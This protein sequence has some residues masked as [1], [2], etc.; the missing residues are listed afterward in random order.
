[1]PHEYFPR[2]SIAVR[3]ILLVKLYERSRDFAGLREI[4]NSCTSDSQFQLRNFVYLTLKT[5]SL[6]NSGTEKQIY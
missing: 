2:Q 6:G 5:L 3:T 4:P 1:M